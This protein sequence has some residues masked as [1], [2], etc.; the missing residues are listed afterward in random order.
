MGG[1]LSK[2][3]VSSGH[4]NVGSRIRA[5]GSLEA[6]QTAMHTLD[7]YR[8]TVV[9]C[10]YCPPPSL[11]NMDSLVTLKSS[12]INALARVV[13][14]HPY[15]HVGITGEHSRH[16]AFVRIG[17]LD[18]RD[19]VEWRSCED[20]SQLEQVYA[21]TMQLQLDSRFDHLSTRPGWRLVVLHGRE[22]NTLDVLY[23]W[24][25]AHHDGM[26]GKIF[27][28]HLLRALNEASVQDKVLID[29]SAP[30]WTLD[31]PNDTHKLPPNGEILC[32]WP[33]NPIFLL[34]WFYNDFKPVSFF[35]GSPHATWAPIQCVPYATRF[36][37]FTVRA[38]T[39]TNLV[40]ACRLHNTTV[41][42]LIHA[43]VLVSLTSSLEP[44]SGTGF[45][46]RTPYDLRHYL[47]ASTLKYPWL[48]PKESMCNYVSALDHEKMANAVTDA[49]P[50]RSLPDDIVKTIWAV[51]A[52]VR[53]QIAARLAS[54]LRNDLIAVMGYCPDWNSHQ[55][56]E[57]R[58]TR[59]LSWLVTNLGVLDGG[60]MEKDEW[61]LRKAE[62]ILSAEVPSAAVS[63]S[64]MTVKSEQM[65]IT[66][67]W[68]DGVVEERVGEGLLLDLERW[69]NEIGA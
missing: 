60:S 14:D 62:L 58:R 41:T 44:A 66:C 59:Y 38:A 42:G 13:L 11:A 53:A 57:A 9:A 36:R 5:M 29:I 30:K 22:V 1:Y 18:L 23:V 45:A 31:L 65:C 3:H 37:T 46:S 15:L 19:H 55:R 16:P 33:L 68:Q 10:R 32:S 51:S 43:L 69:V 21:D 27:H 34:K 61:S 48:I 67:S 47:P 6:Y 4:V 39:V 50:S 40:S 52:R 12:L 24:N 63:V 49:G 26:S 17:Q 64:I 35:P 25:H 54:G 2:G 8:G 28:R 56:R 7:Q 20:A